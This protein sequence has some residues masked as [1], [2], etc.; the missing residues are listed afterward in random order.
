SEALSV[1]KMAMEWGLSEEQITIEEQS[2][3][4]AENAKA[5]RE[6]L[7]SLKFDKVLLVTSA[8]HMKR[9]MLQFEGL[10]LKPT[11]YPVDF[12]KTY[13]DE[14]FFHYIG[15]TNLLMWQT[16]VHE[17]IGRAYYAIRY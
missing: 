7:Q 9:A 3:N 13:R 4:T 15:W 16:A 8:T 1:K 11:A 2:R 12:L 5:V 10:G 14:P 17:T 6:L